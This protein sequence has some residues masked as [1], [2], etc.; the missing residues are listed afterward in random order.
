MIKKEKEEK[1]MDITSVL[2]EEHQN[3]LRVFGKLQVSCDKLEQ[4]GEL[5]KDYFYQV[6]DF[7]KNYADKYHH[8]KEE[9]ILF[10]AM[11]KK[12]DHLH[13][14]PIPVMLHE[15]DAGRFYVQGMEKSL[16]ANDLESLIESA[17]NYCLLLENHIYKEDH[18][19]YPMA[20]E[21]L[22]DEEKEAVNLRYREV[23]MKML[24]NQEFEGLIN[25]E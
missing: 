22:N 24:A 15:H 3:I 16:A 4:G 25:G 2:S 13:C 7:I 11:L 18:V 9:D 21:A 6:I 5:D 12:L 1:I 19:L 17:R 23:E 20:E 8:A 14:N 10:Q